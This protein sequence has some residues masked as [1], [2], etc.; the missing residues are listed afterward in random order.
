MRIATQLRVQ[1]LLRRC[2]GAGAAGFVVRR[3]DPERGALFVKVATLDGRARLHG[4][5]AAS[6]EATVDDGAL[7]PHLSPD[8]VPEGEVD[9]YLARQVDYDADLW[10]VE[11]EDRAGRSFLDD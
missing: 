6:L 8:G 10:I 3:G 11:I 2:S 4:P 7:T 5:R 9:A 1:A